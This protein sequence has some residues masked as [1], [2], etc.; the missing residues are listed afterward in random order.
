MDGKRVSDT[1]N[2]AM[3]MLSGKGNQSYAVDHIFS[4]KHELNLKNDGF[5]LY[6][7]SL[8]PKINITVINDQRKGSYSFNRSDDRSIG[9]AVEKAMEISRSSVADSGNA[10]APKNLL[11]IQ[12][13]TAPEREEMYDRLDE[14]MSEL[15]KD[16][17]EIIV[18]QMI[19]DY[20]AVTRKYKNSNEADLFSRRGVYSLGMMFLAKNDSISTSF[21]SFY[22]HLNDLQK[23]LM[24]IADM[25][26]ILKNTVSSLYAEHYPGSGPGVV[27]F[28]PNCFMEFL[29][30]FSNYL[31]DPWM[32][33]G[34]SPL[35]N[36]MGKN[37]AS[38]CVSLRSEPLNE[39]LAGGYDFTQDGFPAEDIDVVKEGT[40]ENYLISFYGSR[41]TGLPHRRNRGGAWNIAPGDRSLEGLIGGIKKGILLTR[42]SGGYPSENG[43]FSGVAKNSFLIRDGKL[44]HALKETMVSGNLMEIMVNIAGI[45]SERIDYGHSIAPW[46]A[47]EGIHITGR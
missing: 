22:V 13:D 42:F 4:E 14:Y 46:A 37:V 24:E 44:S 41:K 25:R 32:I 6:R 40:L 28:S 38:R 7:T 17:P 39:G 45:S 16:Y 33:S 47:A 26:Q 31:K 35:K 29:T 5:T 18:E 10:L 19:M 15:K 23:P 2:K 1:V 9:D 20:E 3:D 34:T 43:D 11:N 36:L 8:K 21:K 12:R 27:L 30:Y